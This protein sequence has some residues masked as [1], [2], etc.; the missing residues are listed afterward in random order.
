MCQIFENYAATVMIC[1][2]PHTLNLFDTAGQTDFDKLRPLSYP[3][4]DVFIV[5]FS[6]ISPTTFQNVKETWV[7]EI[8]HFC[9]GTPFILVGTQ[10]DLRDDVEV[11]EALAAAQQKA[12]SSSEGARLGR[13][14]RAVKYLEC[15]AL[16]Q[17]G[18]KTVFDEVSPG[19]LSPSH[20]SPLTS[21]LSPLFIQAIMAVLEKSRRPSDSNP[22]HCC[23]VL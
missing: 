3:K 23:K 15:S 2:E 20:L 16:T 7:P 17:K 4:T 5:C 19:C 22:F 10:T 18:L 11:V 9:P 12:V 1:E 13:E 14:V 6:V 8:A 21:P